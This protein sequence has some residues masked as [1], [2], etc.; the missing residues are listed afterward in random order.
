MATGQATSKFGLSPDAALD[1][2][3]EVAA[4]G[5]FAGFHVHAGSQLTDPA[6]HAA[7]LDAL[8]PLYDALP[9]ATELDLG[10]GFAVPGFPYADLAEIVR[11]FLEPRGLRLLLEPG[12]A[13]VA[14][15]GVL[16]TRVQHVK[17]GVR[18]HVIADAGMADL[19]RPALYGAHHPVR[20]LAV[21]RQGGE[22][23]AAADGAISAA[24]TDV[25]GPLCENADRLGQ[26]VELGD[27]RSGDLLAVEL[28]GAYG[29]AMGSWYASHTRAAEVVID[30]GAA[31]LERPREPLSELWRAEMPVGLGLETPAVPAPASEPATWRSQGPQGAQLAAAFAAELAGEPGDWSLSLSLP[32]GSE[33]TMGEERAGPSA[34]L[35][36]LLLLGAALDPANAAPAWDQRV[37][38]SDED[39]ATGSGVLKLLSPGLN[40]TWGDLLTLMMAHSDNLATN[41]VLAHL[42]VEATNAWAAA[43]GLANTRVKG[44]LQVPDERRTPAQL[45]GE[46]AT[47]SAAEVATLTTAMVRP[48]LGWLSAEAAERAKGTLRATAFFNALLRHHAT[49]HG[50]WSYGAKG[51]WLPGL[52]HEV[53]VAFD[54]N[55]RWSGTLAVMCQAHPDMRNHIDHPAPMA[56]GRLGLHFDVA[57]RAA[58]RT[59]AQAKDAGT[60]VPA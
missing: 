44:P 41:V 4:T 10:G 8:A 53:A 6:V 52:R 11:A 35:I 55:G 16:L 19:L 40:P 22:D 14:Q 5:R 34:S 26:D 3:R 24:P 2:A 43:H 20:A 50:G 36:K 15:A 39:H 28:G 17:D 25:D 37:Q 60:G 57:A 56:L 27:V 13:L 48:E 18:R 54:E 23:R 59:S 7:V 30:D 29:W 51:G 45:R 58:A 46:Y 38:L 49:P 21:G 42:G 31:R 9:E 47:T 32:D 1:L 12:R 33:V